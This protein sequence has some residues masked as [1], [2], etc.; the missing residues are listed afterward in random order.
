M[1][2]HPN[3]AA[4]PTTDKSTVIYIYTHFPAIVNK[5]TGPPPTSPPDHEYANYR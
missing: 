3:I 2:T 1:D 5:P 4:I